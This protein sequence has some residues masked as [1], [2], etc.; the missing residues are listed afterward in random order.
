M[1]SAAK[2]DLNFLGLPESLA[3]LATARVAIL[4]L[5]LEASTTYGK[6]TARGPQAILAAS[7]QVELYD[8]ELQTTPCEIGISTQQ[9]F[10]QFEDS[11]EF[12]LQQIASECARLLKMDKFVVGLGGE[13]SI[14]V[15]LV[16]AFQA[17]FPDLWVLQ[18]D[19]HSDMRDSYMNSKYNH[20]CVMARVG[21]ICPFIG[22]GIRSSL[23]DE[24]E[25]LKGPSRIIYAFEMQQNQAWPDLV[26]AHLGDPVYL[27]IDLDFFDPGIMPSVGTPEPGGFYWHE[28]L[29]FL[30]R[31][32]QTHTVV[33]FDVV[34]LRPLP[35]LSAPDFTA[36]KLVYKLIGYQFANIVKS[37][38]KKN[39]DC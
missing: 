16:Q 36:A 12:S 35:N 8:E 26:L 22:V 38:N 32:V 5:P 21:E 27:T 11:I 37:G 15:G 2:K 30:K 14:T 7:H 6:G 9:P 13:H 3:D 39:L 10:A 34:E 20:A 19:A 33:G 23:R 4:C 28:T 1:K 17:Q 24:Q 29:A 31:V 18:L 25:A